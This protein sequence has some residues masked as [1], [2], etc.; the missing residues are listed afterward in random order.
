[1][2]PHHPDSENRNAT[3]RA[4]RSAR[5]LRARSPGG[6]VDTPDAA[7]GTGRPPHRTERSD[8]MDLTFDDSEL[9]LGDL[10]VTAMRDA[11]A[12]PETGASAAA[13]SCSSTSCCCCQQ[14][15]LPTQ[16]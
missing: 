3:G 6:S 5:G 14:P 16:G 11:V 7:R 8:P 9:D 2:T 12:L 1:M 4:D 10:A 15:E 13:C